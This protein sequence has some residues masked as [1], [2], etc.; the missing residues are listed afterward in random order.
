MEISI[1]ATK[2]RYCGE[3]V[4]RPRDEARHLTVKDLGGESVKHYV[5]PSSVMEALEAFRAEEE[6]AAAPEVEAAGK[7]SYFG[8]GKKKAQAPQP[9]N[10]FDDLP[11]LDAHG[12][13]LASIMGGVPARGSVVRTPAPAGPSWI[14]KVGVFAGLVAAIV[15]L[16]L[17]G[18]S[19]WAYVNRPDD[20][21]AG[22]RFVNPAKA[23]IKQDRPAC[24][25]LE[26]A[27]EA[28][29]R[30]PNAEN[31]E[32]TEIARLRVVEEIK[33]LLNAPDWTLENNVMKASALAQRAHEADPSPLITEIKK[34]VEKE[35]VVCRMNWVGAEP[36]RGT[37]TLR[38]HDAHG[39]PWEEV[40]VKKGELIHNRF[41]LAAVFRDHIE[42]IDRLRNNRRVSYGPGMEPKSID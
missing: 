38:I 6:I 31:R 39:A 41:E 35:C 29:L 34:E 40:T 12:Q 36:D 26:A 25:I 11:D 23:M 4:G 17:G 16:Y 20:A 15:I 3:N 14:R 28:E 27:V 30:E 33:A 10:T 32:I 7:R 21:I 22:P 18:G 5:P 13:D 2:C 42:V 37:A 19:I 24:E 8:L 9:K 1:L